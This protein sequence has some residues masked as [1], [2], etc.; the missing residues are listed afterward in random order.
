MA[1]RDNSN[2]GEEEKVN[3][4][5]QRLHGGSGFHWDR[6]HSHFRIPVESSAFSKTA[7]SLA[8]SLYQDALLHGPRI[9]RSFH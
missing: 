2:R 4:R 1:G 3:G 7:H 9:N 8:M 6:R 5:S